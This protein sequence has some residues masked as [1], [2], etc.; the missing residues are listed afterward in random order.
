ML[1][2]MSKESAVVLPAL[3]VLGDYATSRMKTASRYVRCAAVGVAYLVWLWF[4]QGRR[5]GREL[6]PQIDNPL[7]EMP[8]VWRV[9]NASRV[10]WRYV[11][12][13][14]YPRTLS[15]DYSFNATPVS[16]D[17]LAL[18]PA[19]LGILAG[20]ALAIWAVMRGRGGGERGVARGVAIACGIYFIRFATTSNFLIPTGTIMGERLAYRSSAGF[21]LLAALAWDWLRTRQSKAA[22]AL[23][24]IAVGGARGAYGS[25]QSRLARQSDARPRDRRRRAGQLK[26]RTN[27]GS[28]LMDGGDPVA[29]RAIRNRVSHRPR[30]SGPARVVWIAAVSFR[31]PR[32]R[33]GHDGTSAGHER[34]GQSQLRVDRHELGGGVEHGSHVDAALAILNKVIV[35]TPGYPRALANRAVIEYRRGDLPAARSDAE[36]AL[37]VDWKNAQAAAVLRLLAK[38]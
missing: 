13:Q 6:I 11:W 24:A 25:P 28:L 9:L 38:P 29:A 8:A 18:L 32:D 17:W 3:I 15:A 27:L 5:L 31:T 7:G 26:A 16:H 21:C 1:A 22:F 10:A 12:L 19:L 34:A 4:V 2:M 35:E 37:A 36:R 23:L 33:G 20:A 30:F 14:L